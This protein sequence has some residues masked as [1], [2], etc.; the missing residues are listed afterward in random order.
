M[1]KNKKNIIP[2]SLQPRKTTKKSIPGSKPKVKTEKVASIKKEV[3]APMPPETPKVVATSPPPI[4]PK[5]EKKRFTLWLHE[6]TFRAFKVHVAM[7]GGSAS[8]Y[9]ESLIKKDLKL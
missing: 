2:P 3:P 6:E 8:D 5:T 9:I 1:A 4:N 7:R